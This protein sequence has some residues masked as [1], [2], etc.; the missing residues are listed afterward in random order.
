MRG[1]I[2]KGAVNTSFATQKMP[3]NFNENIVATERV[4]QKLRKLFKL[5][6]SA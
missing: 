2:D 3:L 1:K 5:P 6:R 4:D